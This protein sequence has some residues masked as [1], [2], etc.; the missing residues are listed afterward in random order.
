MYRILSSLLPGIILITLT[1]VVLLISSTPRKRTQIR[2]AFFQYA[3]RPVLDIAMKGCEEGLKRRGFIDKETVSI[4][5]YNAEGDQITTSSISK[6]IIDEQFDIALTASTL[7]LQS[8]AAANQQGT[9]IHVFGTVTDPF[10]AGV[11][12]DA[13]D[14][15]KH[16]PWLVGVG[17]M[18]PV[19]TAFELARAC[20]PS[21]KTIGTV[22]CPNEACSMACLTIGQGIA[23]EMGITMLVAQANN[24]NDVQ[25]ATASLVAKGVEAIFIG[26]D[27]LVESVSH[28]VINVARKNGIPVIAYASEHAKIGALLGVGVDYEEMGVAQGELAGDILNGKIDPANYSIENFNR[29][30]YAVNRNAL[31]DLTGW[32]LPEKVTKG[33]SIVYDAK[34]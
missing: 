17:S 6:V 10:G 1:S 12:I 5:R 28:A 32:S 22:M 23:K 16:P 7:C 26:G 18:Q 19:R 27:N 20:N 8:L 29:S 14:H 21:L 4:T 24:T 9:I 15:T 25:D 11:G 2:V 33:A 30:S 13:Q 31:K 34:E 3:S